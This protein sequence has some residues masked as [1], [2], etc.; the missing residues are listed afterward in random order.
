VA[1]AIAFAGA[2]A[3]ILTLARLAPQRRAEVDARA[4]AAHQL[5]NPA[6]AV[7]Y[8]HAHAVSTLRQATDLGLGGLDPAGFQP[9]QL[10]HRSELALLDGLSWLPERVAGAAR[11]GRPDA[12]ARFLEK[13]ARAYLECQQ[14]RPA[15]RPGDAPADERTGAWQQEWSDGARSQGWGAPASQPVAARLWLVAAARAALGA[16]LCLLGTSPPDRL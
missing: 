8:A 14:N 2:D 10:A 13:L 9:R 1:D 5:A 6:Y 15:V 7:R 4:A 12:F 11:R 3:V 16:G